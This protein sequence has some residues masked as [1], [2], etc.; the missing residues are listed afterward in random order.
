MKMGFVTIAVSDL[1]RSKHFYEDTLGFVPETLYE[2]W[3]PY[4]I[5]GSGGFGIIEDSRT[6]RVQ[7][8]DIVNFAL[9]D[10]DSL[11]ARIEGHVQVES[12][13]QVMP[14]GTRKFVILDP[15]GMRLGFCEA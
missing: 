11:W 5:D 12:P 13:P 7:C 9:S 15:D 3:Q 1:A 10:I 8:L 4:E 14:W 2:R 6:H